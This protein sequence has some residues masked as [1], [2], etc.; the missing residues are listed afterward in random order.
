MDTM[1]IVGMGVIGIG[2]LIA[3]V[4]WIWLI[5]IGFQKGGALWGI[6][7]IFCQPIT[8]IIFCIM[9]KTGWLPLALIIIGNVIAGIGMVPLM[10]AYIKMLEQMK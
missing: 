6:L 2:T 8:G 10:P 1:G 9:H 7:N 5:V 4:G 3:L